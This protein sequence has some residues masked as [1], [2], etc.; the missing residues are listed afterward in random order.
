MRDKH[1]RAILGTA[2]PGLIAFT[3]AL[4]LA[5][6]VYSWGWL[7][8]PAHPLADVISGGVPLAVV[9]PLLALDV[10]TGVVGDDRGTVH[11]IGYLI[12]TAIPAACVDSVEID[13]G[14]KVLATSGLRVGTV[15]YGYSSTAALLKYKRARK[16]QRRIESYGAEHAGS[17]RVGADEAV[18]VSLRWRAALCSLLVG[19]TLLGGTVLLNHVRGA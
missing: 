6:F 8:S 14:L 17:S 3:A 9:V 11:V 16:A 5:A 7:S 1:R 13:G 15:A 12:S 19:A 10:T 2:N 4:F 18:R